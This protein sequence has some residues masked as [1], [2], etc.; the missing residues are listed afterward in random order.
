MFPI[1]ADIT[2]ADIIIGDFNSNSE[3]R[4]WIWTEQWSTGI[5]SSSKLLVINSRSKIG[6]ILPEQIRTEDTNRNGRLCH[7][8]HQSNVLQICI[9]PLIKNT[10]SVYYAEANAVIKPHTVPF[11]RIFNFKKANWAN[12]RSITEVELMQV[13]PSPKNYN[14]FVRI[15][16]K[17]SRQLIP[18]GCQQ[19][20]VPGLTEKSSSK[21]YLN[22]QIA[23]FSTETIKL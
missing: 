17:A 14:K 16:C 4:W 22:T 5:L 7:R 9:W 10:T 19:Q 6:T 11:G 21:L 23:P 12:F 18:R 8:I 20:Y 2:Q 1:F 13:E 15:I 3:S